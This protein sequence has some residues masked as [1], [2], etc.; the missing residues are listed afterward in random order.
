MPFALSKDE[1]TQMVET[2]K[3]NPTAVHY[4]A[5]CPKCRKMTKI[6]KKQFTLNPV[7]KKMLE[8]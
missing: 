1:I 5:Q 3:A 6:S 8:G 2:F 4:D 7:Y